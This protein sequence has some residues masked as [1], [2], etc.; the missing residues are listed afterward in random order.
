MIIPVFALAQITETGSRVGISTTTPQSKLSIFN[1][2]VGTNTDGLDGAVLYINNG[3]DADGSIVIKSHRVGEGNVIGALK[4]HS[5]PDFTNFSQASLKAIAGA[6]DNAESLAF[7]TS[8][9]NTQGTASNEVMRIKG[10]RIGIGT[11]NPQSKLSLYVA[12][13]GRNTDGLDGAIF[14]LNNGNNP[15]GSIIIKSH[16]VTEG[17]VIG[18]LKFHSSPDLTNFSQASIKVI[19]GSGSK[20]ESIA[21]F[22]STSNSQG[23][24]SNEVMRI[25]GNQ[26]GFGTNNPDATL[27]VKG[28]IHAQEVR[29]DLNGA[30]APDFVFEEDYNLPS[31]QQTEAF[32]KANKHLPEIPSAKEME[33][34]GMELKSMN[35]KLLQKVEELTLHLIQ[36]QKKIQQLEQEVQILKQEK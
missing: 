18:A 27:A 35:L 26:V 30:V 29:V 8:T 14:Y 32:I 10:N 1:G 9:S 15:D 16:Q 22:T 11:T 25:R 28:D 20:A 31:L 13:A 4:F 23:T 24:A 6:S 12:S 21:F 2:S 17:N 3:D 36:Q 19:A 34:K 5:S 33:E 7:F